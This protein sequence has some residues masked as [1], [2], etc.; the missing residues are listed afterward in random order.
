MNS[1]YNA[2][3]YDPFI[4]DV[5]SQVVNQPKSSRSTASFFQYVNWPHTA[6]NLLIVMTSASLYIFLIVVLLTKQVI[7][8]WNVF[9]SHYFVLT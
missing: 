9:I 4:G 8:Q 1:E 3:F 6:N 5:P 7:D 2:M